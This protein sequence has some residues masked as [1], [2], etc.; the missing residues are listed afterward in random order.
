MEAS[1]VQASA[2]RR[3]RPLAGPAKETTTKDIRCTLGVH[4]HVNGQVE[5]SQYRVCSRCGKDGPGGVVTGP[6]ACIGGGI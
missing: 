3:K 2:A 1:T 5:D 4:E 6:I